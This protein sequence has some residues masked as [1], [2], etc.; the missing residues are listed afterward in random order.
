MAQGFRVMG[1]FAIRGDL[2]DRTPVVHNG[3]EAIWS[4]RK[5]RKYN[6]YSWLCVVEGSVAMMVDKF[7]V[8]DSWEISTYGYAWIRLGNPNIDVYLR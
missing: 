1:R 4:A 2:E 6:R 8:K 3:C 5:G 7:S